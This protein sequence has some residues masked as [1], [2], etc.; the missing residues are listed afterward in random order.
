[1]FFK[2]KRRKIRYQS[3]AVRSESLARKAA[4]AQRMWMESDHRLGSCRD[5]LCDTIERLSAMR[6]RNSELQKLH[7]EREQELLAAISDL[8]SRL[9]AATKAAKAVPRKRA[10]KSKPQKR[11]KRE[12]AAPHAVMH[13]ID[14]FML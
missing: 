3:I 6:I 13:S 4:Q 14:S 9:E 1:M 11:Q 2:R 5:R 7:A 8:E 12:Q 10:R